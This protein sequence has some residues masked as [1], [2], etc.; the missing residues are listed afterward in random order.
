MRGGNKVRA[1][2]RLYSAPSLRTNIDYL[3]SLS[4]DISSLG[5]TVDDVIAHGL[6]STTAIADDV[7][8]SNPAVY[9]VFR[10]LIDEGKLTW[11]ESSALF[12][13]TYYN[14]LNNVGGSGL[15]NPVISVFPD[16]V[17][18]GRIMDK[19]LKRLGEAG[20]YLPSGTV[21]T[22]GGCYPTERMTQDFVS[23][24]E[25]GTPT[26]LPV[27]LSSST[28]NSGIV[29]R[30][31]ID[32][33]YDGTN[34]RTVITITTKEGV[35]VDDVAHWGSNFNASSNPGIAS[36]PD[37]PYPQFEVLQRPKRQYEVVDIVDDYDSDWY[38]G[39]LLKRI[40]LREL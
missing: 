9:S 2:E 34:I 11:V 27:V 36:D 19:A 5:Y 8:R 17:A 7:M 38:P 4:G 29:A 32:R 33:T 15:V 14:P 6:H 39:E 13:Y 1:W 37:L 25:N 3:K 24:W 31:F 12:R 35:Y 21:T 40:T 18:A 22:R 28:D 20:Y 10:N 23:H 16:K 26:T 30:K